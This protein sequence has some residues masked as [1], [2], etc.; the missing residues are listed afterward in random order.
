MNILITGITGQDGIFLIKKLLKEYKY[1]NIFGISRSYKTSEFLEIV[2]VR[3][4]SDTQKIKLINLDLNNF[5]EVFKFLKDFQPD[6]VFNLS[7]PSSVYESIKFPRYEYQIINIFNNLIESLVKT[8]NF[9]KFFQASTSEMFGLNNKKIVYDESSKFIP[10]SPYA[11]GKLQNHLKIGELKTKYHWDI[12]SGI[13]FN[14]ESEYRKE[15]Y[16]FT[17]LIN[18]AIQIQK[19]KNKK[20]TIGSLEVTRD[21]SYAGDIAEGI[22]LII[23]NG[24]SFDYVLGSGIETK[25]KQ[26]VDIIFSYFNL[27][28]EK[29]IELNPEILRKND[30]IRMVANPKKIN[31][32]V[33]WKTETTIESMIEK[34][35]KSKIK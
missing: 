18:S 33:G 26:L 25:I 17:K 27:N 23:Q 28:Y 29:Y 22:F 5:D 19:K 31:T 4:I 30:P 15:N 8:N 12:Y 7:G 2:S 34:I 35:I 16:L 6:L 11:R 1:L 9:C 14:H 32:E 10:N 21:W 20:F 24:R 3:N 13:M